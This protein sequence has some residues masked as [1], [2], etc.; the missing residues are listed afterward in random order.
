MIPIY[1]NVYFDFF[2]RYL[3]NYNISENVTW[4]QAIVSA[5]LSDASDEDIE[6]DVD[7]DINVREGNV[8]TAEEEEDENLVEIDD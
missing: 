7:L 1:S 2:P 5:F 4:S 6:E 8:G 3:Q